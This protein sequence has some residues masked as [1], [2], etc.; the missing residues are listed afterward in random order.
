METSDILVPII[1]L[2]ISTVVTTTIGILIKRSFDKFFTKKQ[3]EENRQKQRDEKLCEHETRQA[4][5]ERKKDIREA[6]EEAVEPIKQDLIIIKKG[7]QAGLRHDLV[8]LADEWIIKGYCPREVKVD[9]ENLYNQYHQLGKNGV[10]DNTYQEIL[11]L[12]ETKPKRITKS[13]SR[14]AKTTTTSN[15]IK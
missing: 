14:K 6:I 12:P 9:F 5:E 3:E 10:M 15:E 4:R 1:S 11:S 8:L 7:T 13:T 2:I